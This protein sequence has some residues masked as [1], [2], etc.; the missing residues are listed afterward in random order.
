[1]ELRS[2][3]KKAEKVQKDFPKPIRENHVFQLFF[4]KDGE[5]QS[6]E[7]AEVKEIDFAEV[8]QH[9]N[10]GKSIFIKRKQTRRRNQKLRLSE[11][12]REHWYFTHI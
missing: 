5:Y 4:L 7:V 2:I 10:Q 11:D 9:L 6:V 8:I 3:V 1:M 12:R